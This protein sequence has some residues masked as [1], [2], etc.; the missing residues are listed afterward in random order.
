[1][2]SGLSSSCISCIRWTTLIISGGMGRTAGT[3]EPLGSP[4]HLLYFLPDLQGQG[5]F[6]PIFPIRFHFAPDYGVV[7]DCTIQNRNFFA[8][9]FSV[10]YGRHSSRRSSV[11][12][13][14]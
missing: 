12:T 3:A 8:E 14:R 7:E 9:G 11:E 6:L 10:P 2:R 4:Q 13:P 5:S 1:M